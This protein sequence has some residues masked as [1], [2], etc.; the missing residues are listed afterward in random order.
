ML[1]KYIQ[2]AMQ[3]A[4]YEFSDEDGLF[5][6]EIPGFQ[7]VWMDSETLED[8]RVQLQEVLEEWIVLGLQLGH[9]FPAVDGLELKFTKVP[10]E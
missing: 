3:H 4:T 10:V 9:P 7:G 1:T 5:I 8:C 2:A 6:G